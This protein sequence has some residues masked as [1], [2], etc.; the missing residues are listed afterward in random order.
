MIYSS[1]KAQSAQCK[2]PEPF[3]K[4][5]DFLKNSDLEHMEVGRYEIDG[6]DIYAMIQKQTTAAPE[7]K[8]AESH[9]KYID[10]Q[11][12]IRGEE[13]QGVAP[14]PEGK[15]LEEHP[16]RDVMYYSE[17][18]GENFIQLKPGDFAVYFTNDIHR[19]NCAPGE[20]MEIKKVVL[21]IREAIL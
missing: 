9:Y 17:V 8:K 12:L 21:K 5:F 4:A 20:S 2:W 6:D 16:E 3:Q 18:A 15:E 14:L 7:N 13:M 19:P 1:L 11:Y 10:I